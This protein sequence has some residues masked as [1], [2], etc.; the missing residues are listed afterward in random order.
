M[1]SLDI[2]FLNDR[3]EYAK[4]KPGGEEETKGQVNLKE[5]T[6]LVVGIVVAALLAGGAFQFKSS[7]D[8]ANQQ[9]EV[10]VGQATSSLGEIEKKK[11]RIQAI[12][13]E[14]EGINAQTEALATVFNQIKPW[15]ALLQEL[16]D[17]A[18]AG[19][20]IASIQQIVIQPPPPSPGN[21]TAIDPNAP[22]EP[23][24]GLDIS[25]FASSYSE[26][27]NLLLLLQNSKFFSGQEAQLVSASMQPNPV[28]VETS[29]EQNVT[30]QLPPVVKYQVKV[31]L[32]SV[33]ASEILPELE[34][35]GAVGLVSRIESLEKIMNESG[36][37]PQ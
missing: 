10:E 5:A 7:L 34:R 33:P 9:L 27:N 12:K 8:R 23:R 32:S 22:K 11:E 13:Q 19:I 14:T 30:V 16:R 20:Q 37:F 6:P 2:N 3:P 18:P 36:V 31:P 29:N 15:S 17:R 21:P 25:G 4:Q 24:P 35:K 28:R 26:V 1:Y